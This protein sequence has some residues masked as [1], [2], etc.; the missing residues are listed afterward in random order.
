MTQAKILTNRYKTLL[1]KNGIN[2]PL[3]L[4][5]FWGQ[6][7]HE[8]KLL[9]R[10]ENLNYSAKRLLEIF[11]SDFDTNRDKWLSPQEKE[12]VRELIGH[13]NRIANFVY[14]NQ[15]GNGNE[16]SG[17]G[18]RYRGRG[19]IQI[20]LKDNYRQLSKDAGI[21]FLNNPDLLLEE[22][23][24]L[25]AAIWFWN[26]HKLNYYSDRQDYKNMTKIINGGFNGLEDR[27]KH[28]NYYKTTFK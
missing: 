12:K 7:Y 15:G 16:A 18:W 20:T 3:R 13:P 19:A 22:A 10:Q 5:A 26:K 25:I 21:D 2:T 24:S 27:I 6:L 23:N 9:P 11:K 1:N 28:I 4:A 8:S 14:A 17:D